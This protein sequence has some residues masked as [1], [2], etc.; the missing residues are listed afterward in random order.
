[1]HSLEPDEEARLRAHLPGCAQCRK[2]V[3]ATEEVTAMLGGSVRQYDPPPRLRARLMD[4][5]E[6]TP[7]EH[8]AQRPVAAPVPLERHRRRATGGLGR[9]LLAAAAVVVALVAVGVAGVRFNQL[10]DRVAVQEQRNRELNEALLLAASPDTNRAVMRSPTGGE[11]VAIVLSGSDRAAVMEM[12][13]APNNATDQTYVV[14]GRS[15]QAPVPLATFDVSAEDHRVRLL[16][17]SPDAHKHS[18]F[19]ISLEQ[20][21]EMP[22]KPSSVVALGQ[23]GAA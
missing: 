2:A 19:A 10:N 4:A 18:E 11:P 14:W 16:S 22:V 13:L 21:R 9:R 6:H 23:V 1:M 7:Q 12:K 17:W 15:T 20:G 3:R 8:V 5:V